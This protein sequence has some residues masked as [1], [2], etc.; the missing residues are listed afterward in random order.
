[1]WKMRQWSAVANWRCRTKLHASLGLPSVSICNIVLVGWGGWCKL[2]SCECLAPPTVAL[3]LFL[4]NLN[5]FSISVISFCDS[6][7][8]WFSGA[9]KFQLDD[10]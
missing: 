3:L 8:F 2:L 1:M 4:L 5:W 9:L 7:N 10:A 6:S